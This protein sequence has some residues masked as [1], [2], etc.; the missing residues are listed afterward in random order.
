MV[1]LMFALMILLPVVLS[2]VTFFILPKID[3]YFD[4]TSSGVAS[5]V[6]LIVSGIITSAFFFGSIG[7]DTKDVEVLNG[8]ITDKTRK[9]GSYNQSYNCNCEKV[10]KKKV[11]KDVCQTCYEKRY[12]VSWRVQSNLGEYYIDSLDNTNPVTLKRDDPVSYKN[13]VVGE[14]CSTTHTYT[15][16]IKAV[17]ETLFRPMSSGLKVKYKDLIPDYPIEIYDIWKINRVLPVKVNV[18]DLK[19]WNYKLSEVLKVLGPIKQVNA[20]IVLVNS[21][22]PDYAYALQDAWVNGKKNDVVLIIGATNFP[23]KADWVR[24]LAFSET[25]MFKI[26]LRDDILNLETLTADGV[27]SVL[28]KDISELYKRKQMKDWKYLK[29]EIVP[30]DWIIFLSSSI[31]VFI[32]LVLWFVIYIRRPDKSEM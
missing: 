22:D 27:T 9:Q 6:S 28:N 31:V 18:P 4:Y 19:D 20:V 23:N 21:S 14:S 25:E 8:Q 11:C 16:Y 12:Y 2:I 26:K 24:V 17:P 15:N 1:N 5:V 30:P 13:V 7:G 32:Y 10:C 3:S 29:A